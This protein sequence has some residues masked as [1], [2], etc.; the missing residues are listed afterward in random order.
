M[1]DLTERDLIKSDS[2]FNVEDFTTD[3]TRNFKTERDRLH[4]FRLHDR[5]LKDG[6]NIDTQRD[7]SRAFEKPE[8]MGF[9]SEESKTS[10][11]AKD[12]EELEVTSCATPR[13]RSMGGMGDTF[14]RSLLNT[15][16]RILM[17]AKRCGCENASPSPSLVK[18]I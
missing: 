2:A 15:V 18:T 13:Q 11:D 4:D 17:L 3:T 6:R 8:K 5:R 16:I 12:S 1:G 10:S 14:Q 9:T 7:P